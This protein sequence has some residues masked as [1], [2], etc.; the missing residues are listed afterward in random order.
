MT[1]NYMYPDHT[2]SEEARSPQRGSRA[3]AGVRDGSGH[4][5]SQRHAAC[6]DPPGCDGPEP[7]H[8]GDGA[9]YAGAPLV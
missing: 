5:V 7:G 8:A 4:E 3:G 6:L 1:G 9:A 2:P